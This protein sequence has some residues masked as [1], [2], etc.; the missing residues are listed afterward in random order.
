VEQHIKLYVNDFTFELGEEGYGA[1][2][3]LLARAAA[4]DLVPPVSPAILE[5]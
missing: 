3:E 1:V 2:R 4:A 5:I